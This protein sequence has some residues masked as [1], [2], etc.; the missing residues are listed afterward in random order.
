LSEPALSE[1][2]ACEPPVA[3]DA[4]SDV[5]ARAPPLRRF[6]ARIKTHAWRRRL[7]R[8]AVVLLGDCVDRGSD[9][10][11]VVDLISSPDATRRSI[12]SC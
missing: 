8:P 9:S 5:G 11:E 12:P 7:A 1:P 6:V 10:A 2:A 4:V 3:V